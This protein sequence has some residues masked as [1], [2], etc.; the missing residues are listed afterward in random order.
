[1]TDP[2]DFLGRFSG[3]NEDDKQDQ[4]EASSLKLV[5]RQLGCPNQRVEQLK[6][7]LGPDF[8]A[9][10]FNNQGWIGPDLKF[11]RIFKFKLDEFLTKPK[12][13]PVILAYEQFFKEHNGNDL[14]MVFKAF[15]LGRMVIT[16]LDL[17][18]VTHISTCTDLLRINIALMDDFFERMYG[19]DI[20]IDI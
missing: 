7:E 8:G 12:K 17:P 15:E 2:D 3:S 20:L 1:V 14:I 13:H 11:H 16:C 6:R 18:A 5:L 9:D 19:N 10:W 4:F